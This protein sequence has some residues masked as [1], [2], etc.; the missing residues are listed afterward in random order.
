MTRTSDDRRMSAFLSVKRIIKQN[1]LAT[2]LLVAFLI[3]LLY[4]SV[5]MSQADQVLQDK[6]SFLTQEYISNRGEQSILSTFLSSF[7]TNGLYLGVAFL[8]GFFALG[9]PFSVFIMLFRGFGLG[10]AM[11]NIYTHHQAGGVLYCMVFIVPAAVLFTFVMISALKDSIQ[12][13]NLFLA[14]IF[15][16][17]GAV[18]SGET[19]K[20]YCLK[21]AF[22][23][24]LILLI[25][26]LD[27]AINFLFSSIIKL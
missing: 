9:Q 12:F 7:S 27:S 11:G 16:K 10:L 17:L 20:I 5:L 8:L 2:L 15:P 4:G 19:L 24:L 3:A 13:S 18:A 23:L 1:R 22:Y 21:Y 25:S 26:A 6:L 14:S